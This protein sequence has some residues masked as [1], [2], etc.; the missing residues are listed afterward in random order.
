MKNRVMQKTLA[1]LSFMILSVT[2][3]IPAS[4]ADY[5]I[6]DLGVLGTG[7]Y[8]YPYAVNNSGQ[9]VGYSLNPS[10]NGFIYTSGQG[11]TALSTNGGMGYGIN[12]SGQAVG[13]AK[14]SSNQSHAFVY[15]STGMKDLGTLGGTNSIAKNIN[16]S[17][18][19][20][21]YSQFAAGNN[22]YHAFLYSPATGKM[23]DIGSLG[24]N[25]MD[26]LGLNNSGQVAGYG[27]ITGSTTITHAFLYTPGT[28]M[29]D[30]HTLSTL[31][32]IGTKSRAAGI[33]DS[34]DVIG[35]FDV[36][37]TTNTHAFL[38]SNGTMIDLGTIDDYNGKSQAVGI[39]NLGQVAGY[40]QVTG[41]YNHAFLYTPDGGMQ[42]L[43]TLGGYTSIARGI[44][45]DGTVYGYSNTTT[46]AQH[47]F[48]Y[49]DGKMIDLN[50]LL[51]ADSGWGVLS[52]VTG[53]GISNNGRIIGIGTI[54]GQ[55]HAFLMT[56][57]PAAPVPI[58]PAF[59][60]FGSG[61]AGLGFIRGKFRR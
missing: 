8:S 24:G 32:N 36:S 39:N 48:I 61:L 57:P 33:N 34:G 56:P 51:P 3:V 20:A 13:Y 49:R 7:T 26:I 55:T 17:G 19:V 25:S 22:A 18:Q 4:G 59:L 27:Y 29:Q 5:T 2:V 10:I 9:V 44:G 37:G 45:E 30:L 11:M 23:D 15:D 52:D 28:G 6:T 14:N 41:N 38:Y 42:D 43:G 54:S 58:P 16:N 46:G 35:Y 60:L 40:S 12:D 47:A 50:D 21:G 1:L 53:T 31:Q